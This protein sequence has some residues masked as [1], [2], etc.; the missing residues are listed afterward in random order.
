MSQRRGVTLLELVVSCGI[1]VALAAFLLPALSRAKDKALAADDLNRLRQLGQ[2]G[3]IYQEQTGSIPFAC[4][5]VVM[6]GL[7]PPLLCEGTADPVPQGTGAACDYFVLEEER[8]PDPG[9]RVTFVG[10]ANV[11]VWPGS[12]TWELWSKSY[13]EKLQASDGFGWLVDNQRQPK[14]PGTQGWSHPE[15]C[16]FGGPYRRLLTDGAVVTRSKRWFIVK[17]QESYERATW[18]AD[19]ELADLQQ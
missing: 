18:F 4:A 6:A 10:L 16:F 15:N 9:F 3:A 2:A 8:F 11:R 12:A 17:G 1:L 19:I 13:F 5:Q 7:A 14:G